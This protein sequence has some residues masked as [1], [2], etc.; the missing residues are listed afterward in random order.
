MNADQPMVYL[1]DD[2]AS[3]LK[4]LTRI[5]KTGGYAV[6]AFG[7]AD[8]FLKNGLSHSTGCVIVDLYMPGMNGLELQASLAKAGAPL[9]V[10]FLTGHGDIPT[11]VQAMRKGA[12]DFLTKPVK[13][14]KLLDTVRR[15][16]ERNARE[17]ETHARNRELRT[18]YETLTPR[19]REVLARVVTGQ[20]NKQ[21]AADLNK[22][23]R[24]IKI[25][26]A[27][28]MSTLRVRSAAELVRA[29][30]VLGI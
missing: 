16:L 5:L 29:A 8:D 6:K 14:E 4:A 21:I 15:A 13:R 27:N 9:T 23:L 18:L 17:H 19:E 7:S 20:L 30:Q 24:T 26:R 2:D 11:S 1:V 10:V 28:L 12:E 22:C 25:D 3:V